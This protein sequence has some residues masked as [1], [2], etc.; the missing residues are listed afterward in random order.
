[1][2]LNMSIVAMLLATPFFVSPEV[3]HFPSSFFEAKARAHLQQRAMDQWPDPSQILALWKNG[4]L[5]EQEMMAVL[6]GMAASHDPVL[7]PLY[8]EAVMSPNG[9]L[10]MAA[11]YGYR[12]L[13]GDARPDLSGG[14]DLG[15]AGQLATE[16]D[17]VSKTLRER[18]LVEFWL[19]AA[20][21]TDGGSMPGWRGVVL[22]RPQTTCLRAVELVLE[23]D[24]FHY[25]ATA[26][27]LAG[28]TSLRVGLMHLL[29]AITLQQFF[30]KPAGERAGWGTKDLDE[31]LQAADLFV[32]YWTDVQCTTDPSRILQGT[33][34][35]MGVRGLD[36]LA[37]NSYYFW[38]AIL[39]NGASPWHMMA[40]RQLYNFGG[41]WSQLTVLRSESPQQTQARA[42]LIAWYRLLPAH[43]LDRGKPQPAPTP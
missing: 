40:A 26:Y 39:K 36:P 16:M 18:P 4:G 41:R 19:Q 35:D 12:D 23:F 28:A 10:R 37:P 31:A 22:K 15:A 17:A 11:A 7:L 29:E 30:A 13:L 33:M 27:R 25:L 8:R 38:L 42:E 9:G 32:D 2:S 1:M 14:V 5:D 21:T 34:R 43:L 3:A 6:L 20:L 24:D